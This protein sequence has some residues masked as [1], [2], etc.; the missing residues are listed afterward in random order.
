MDAGIAMNEN[1][2]IEQEEE[3][4]GNKKHYGSSRRKTVWTGK[5]DANPLEKAV[6]TWNLA[7]Y[8]RRHPLGADKGEVDWINSIELKNCKCCGGS[9]I[10]HFGK[11][12]SGIKRYY[13]TEC[14]K[15]FTPLTGTIFDNRQIPLS[16]WHD[17]LLDLFSYSSIH[18]ASKGNRNSIN[19]TSYWLKKV[20]LV[21][22]GY[23]D[24]IV[25][26]GNV[27]IDETYVRVIN[28]DVERKSD[29]TMYHGLSRNQIC[30]GIACDEHGHVFC[31]IEGVGHTSKTRTWETFGGHI[32]P[33]SHLIHDKEGCHDILVQKLE[34]TSTAYDSKVIKK[35]PDKLNPLDPINRRCFA[36]KLFLRDHSG[37]DRDYLQDYLNLYA[38][39]SNPPSTK[40]EKVYEF[41]SKAINSNIVLRYR[42]Q[43]IK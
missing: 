14:R 38:F 10:Q 15:T 23:Q 39:I 31:L 42:D 32:E 26:S 6:D 29:G 21:L 5:V 17:F 16:Q 7:N 36:L 4:S 11:L 13:C 19:T 8:D 22:R 41:M 9:S 3:A 37:F 24:D 25:L 28:D 18:L 33:G 35:L 20:F 34:L 43:T 27:Y 40:P 1:E 12:K 30:I 2:E